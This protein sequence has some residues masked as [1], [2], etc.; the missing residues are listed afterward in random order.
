MQLNTMLKVGS[1]AMNVAQDDQVRE[2]F[3]MV[4]QGA[5]RR[6]LIGP[7]SLPP[8]AMGAPVSIA[9]I[10]KSTQHPV[11]F[12]PPPAKPAAV[13]GVGD[14]SQWLSANNAKKALSMAGQ[15]AQ[16]LMK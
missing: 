7:L 2:L 1:L 5:K 12:A 10:A 11:P 3:T 8:N 15:V 6:G 16:L 9:P 13:A 14:V 4:H